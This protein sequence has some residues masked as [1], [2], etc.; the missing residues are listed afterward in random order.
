VTLTYTVELT[1]GDGGVTTQQ[2]PI[3]IS[4]HE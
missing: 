3:T 4:R 2:V 1:D